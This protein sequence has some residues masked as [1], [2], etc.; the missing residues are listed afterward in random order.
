MILHQNAILL[1][2]CNKY[3]YAINSSP[4]SVFLSCLEMIL[5]GKFLHFSYFIVDRSILTDTP[6]PNRSIRDFFFV[7]CG[8]FCNHRRPPRR[9]SATSS[10]LLISLFLVIF[11]EVC[12]IDYVFFMRIDLLFVSSVKE[13]GFWFQMISLSTSG[14]TQIKHYI[15]LASISL[16]D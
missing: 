15:K 2:E 16:E 7:R 5:H 3:Q 11:V 4:I 12:L 8:E 9:N 1:W 6:V 10:I 13:D 14:N